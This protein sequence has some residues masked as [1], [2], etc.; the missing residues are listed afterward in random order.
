M[1]DTYY[2][3]FDYSVCC[4]IGLKFM[5]ENKIK[6]PE[7]L[8]SQIISSIHNYV[9]SGNKYYSRLLVPDWDFPGETD[10]KVV[11]GFIITWIETFSELPP[12][13]VM[14]AF[15]SHVRDINFMDICL[16]YITKLKIKPPPELL[17]RSNLSIISSIEPRRNKTPN[18]WSDESDDS[19]SFV[20]NCIRASDIDKFIT[21][22]IEIF[23][24][25]PSH[26]L[27]R[28]IYAGNYYWNFPFAF[29]ENTKMKPDSRLIKFIIRT[30]TMEKRNKFAECWTKIFSEPAPTEI[31]KCAPPVRRSTYADCW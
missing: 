12:R 8:L 21:T 23:S 10:E 30:Y 16:K 9:T 27:M 24:E 1:E 14:D 19:E 6:P 28:H 26:E 7:Q 5:L 4:E 17:T 18:S 2:Q 11:N 22:W 31:L 13:E 29:I 20:S 15:C 3:D 25:L